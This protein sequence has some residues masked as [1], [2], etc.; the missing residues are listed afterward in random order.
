MKRLTIFRLSLV[1]VLSVLTCSFPAPVRASEDLRRELAEVAQSIQ[2]FLDGRQEDSIAIGQFSGPANFPAS[3]GP[4]LVQVLTEE[5]HKL[6]ISVKTRAKF[7]IKGE[8]R[9]TELP[10]EDKDDARIGVKVLALRIQATIEDSFG[11]PLT[12]FSFQRTIRGEAVLASTI[13]LTAHLNPGGTERERDQTTRKAL[14]DPQAAVQASVVRSTAHSPYAIEILVG[15]R[16][17]AAAL[18]D[19][20][21]FVSIRRGEL[22][23]VRLINDSSL[24]AAV[25]LRIDGLSMFAF[26][27]L[28]QTAKLPDGKQNPRLG[29]PL[30]STVI[31]PAKSSAVIPGWHRTNDKTDSFKVTAYADSAAATLNHTANIGTITATFQAA[32]PE[33]QLAPADEPGKRKGGAGDATGF[34]PP[35]DV[36]YQ[37]V[38]RN[39]GVIRDTIGV[40]YM[41]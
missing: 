14:T 16:S 25:Q 37:E 17:R 6:K 15:G 12:D 27:D 40:R 28:K 33:G 8:Y 23:S 2:K 20:L 32:W 26:S 9:V 19:G 5:L 41:K 35:I 10:A 1:A 38:R 29:E 7:G 34:G 30:Y 24:E 22:Y 11:N 39:L 21:A 18:K 13:G 3:A 36:K 4:G 31:V